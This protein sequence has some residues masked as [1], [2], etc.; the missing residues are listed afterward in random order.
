MENTTLSLVPS[1][2]PIL[3]KVAE[4]FD[5]N[6]PPTDPIALSRLL[7]DAMIA[8]KGYG[9]SACQVGFCGGAGLCVF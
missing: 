9:L 6:N 5:F 8:H 3:R 4:N 1:H 2:D 7:A